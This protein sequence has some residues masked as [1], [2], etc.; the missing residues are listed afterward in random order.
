[1]HQHAHAL[2][3]KPAGQDAGRDPVCGMTVDHDHPKGGQL[4]HGGH[5]F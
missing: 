3:A 1:M 5:T 2:G 4:T